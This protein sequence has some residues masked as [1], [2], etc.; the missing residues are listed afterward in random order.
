VTSRVGGIGTKGRRRVLAVG[1][2][3]VATALMLGVLAVMGPAGATDAA[4]KDAAQLTVQQV[5]ATGDNVVVTGSL[6][7]GDPSK[8]KATV[9]ARPSTPR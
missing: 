1:S 8:L 5:A 6:V 7:N 4:K 9:A 2:G 3:L